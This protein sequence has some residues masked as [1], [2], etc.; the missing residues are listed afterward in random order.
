MSEDKEKICFVVMPIGKRDKGIPERDSFDYWFGIYENVIKPAVENSGAG[1]K[2]RRADHET[3][4]GLIDDDIIE[5]LR[6]S[7]LCVADVTSMNANVYYELGLRD[8]W[9]NRTIIVTQDFA[10]VAF[11]RG[12][13]RALLYKSDDPASLRKFDTQMK[14][15]I[16]EI[17]AN[18]EKVRNPVQS[19]LKHWRG[20][21]TKSV[22]LQWKTNAPVPFQQRFNEILNALG[23]VAVTQLANKGTLAPYRIYGSKNSELS[24]VFSDIVSDPSSL[25]VQSRLAAGI[26]AVLDKIGPSRVSPFSTASIIIPVDGKLEDPE[27]FLR[28]LQKTLERNTPKATYS[29][30]KLM[31]TKT[32]EGLLRGATF[33]L[34]DKIKMDETEKRLVGKTE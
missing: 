11:D 15:A 26:R 20:T 5:G 27:V 14:A 6:E 29:L 25:S 19:F 2:C 8:V 21:V 9:H 34:F 28:A 3:R 4:S 17:V 31:P 33:T 18:P 24:L 30:D 16:T 23:L 12:H 22:E 13:Y 32:Y 10:H 7:F 1:M